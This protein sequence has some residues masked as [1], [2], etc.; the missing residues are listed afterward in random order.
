MDHI[1]SLRKDAMQIATE[2]IQSVLP[3]E[4]VKRALEQFPRDVP[5]RL[6]VIAIGKAAW[7]MA[8]TASEHLGNR[9]TNGLVI[10]KYGHSMGDIPGFEILEA[11]H[12]TPDENSE[13]AAVRAITLVSGLRPE[14][15]VL[16]LLSGGG[17]SLFE[18]PLPG[19]SLEEIKDITRQLLGSGADITEM[20]C[21]R[22]HLSGVKGGR[23]A[24]Q[25]A[26]ASIFSIVL[27]DVLGDPLDVI[28]SGPAFPDAST[29]K[30]ASKIID[31]HKITISDGARKALMQ[32]TPKQLKRCTSTVTGNVGLLCEAAVEAAARLGYEPTILTTALNWEARE[33][34]RFLA[35]AARE[36]RTSQPGNY[37]LI[38]GGET[39]VHLSGS[40]L[41]GRNQELALT[42]ALYMEAL[43]DAVILSI[44]SDGTDGPT[45]AAGGIVDGGTAER[46]RLATGR[47]PQE[48]LTDNDSHHALDASG[49]LILTGPTGT[50]VND[51]MLVLC[52]V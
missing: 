23:F 7:R 16:L 19:V 17:S 40:G 39:V 26:P 41:G 35:G 18:Q 25:C 28:A 10:T 4:A 51:L 2:A 44:G 22:K 21:V 14:D 9:V 47:D 38:L 49:D 3:D 5:G 31:R 20:N 32:E 33:A 8:Q 12:P 48:F 27:S 36:M 1:N 24:E 42:A 50:N 34:G 11:G 43:E 37:A 45:D 46:I 30:E 13:R 6:L 29:S 15:Q 52:H